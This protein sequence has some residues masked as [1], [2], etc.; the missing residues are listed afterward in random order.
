MTYVWYKFLRG[1]NR[2]IFIYIYIYIEGNNE[3]KRNIEYHIP[4]YFQTRRLGQVDHHGYQGLRAQDV[5]FSVSEGQAQTGAT[6][7]RRFGMEGLARQATISCGSQ[8]LPE[9]LARRRRSCWACRG[10]L[11]LRMSVG[12]NEKF[13]REDGGGRRRGVY[14][15]E[16]HSPLKYPLPFTHRGFHSP[17]ACHS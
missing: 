16:W 17:C 11:G 9:E 12:K 2:S 5:Q 3:S 13:E 6:K 10:G 1:K 4:F 15:N 7:R 14:M 8:D